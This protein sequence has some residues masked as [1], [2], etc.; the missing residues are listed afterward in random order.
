VNKARV[1]PTFEV[2]R[3][4]PPAELPELPRMDMAPAQKRDVYP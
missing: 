2:P 4:K 1:T 3:P